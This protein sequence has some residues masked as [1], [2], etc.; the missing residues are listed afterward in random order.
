MKNCSSERNCAAANG[1][2]LET[3]PQLMQSQSERDCTPTLTDA[4]EY[5]WPTEIIFTE[6]DALLSVVDEYL[7]GHLDEQAEHRKSDAF[8]SELLDYDAPQ[9]SEFRE[10]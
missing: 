2:N 9:G 6:I 1:A 5:E 3:R 10:F 4:C 7:R 8:A